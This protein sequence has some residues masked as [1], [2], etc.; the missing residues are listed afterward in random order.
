V[1]LADIES[2]R[3]RSLDGAVAAVALSDALTGDESLRFRVK[4]RQRRLADLR[5]LA[6]DRVAMDQTKGSARGV[7]ENQRLSLSGFNESEWQAKWSSQ[8]ESTH[9]LWR[10]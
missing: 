9:F 3:L 1:D 5:E 10:L 2:L 4:G 8:I 6:H 7:L